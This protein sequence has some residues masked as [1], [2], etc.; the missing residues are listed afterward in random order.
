MPDPVAFDISVRDHLWVLTRDG[1]EVHVYSHLDQATHEAVRIARELDETGQPARVHVHP[2][3][4]KVIELT[5]DPPSV[6]AE[7]PEGG[8]SSALDPHR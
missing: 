5:L 8:A 6:P 1:Q 7:G 4:G 2:S 3:E